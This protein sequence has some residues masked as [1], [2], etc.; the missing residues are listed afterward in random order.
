MSMSDTNYRTVE[1][2]TLVDCNWVKQRL[3][4]DNIC[5]LKVLLQ[6]GSLRNQTEDSDSI[7]I[8]NSKVFNISEFSENKDLPNMMI[9]E[10]DFKRLL[11]RYKISKDA[12]IVFYESSGVYASPRAWWMFY[13]MGF[14]KISIMS[15]SIYG[16]IKKGYPVEKKSSASTL[17]ASLNQRY[18][19]DDS[20]FC[21]LSDIYNYIDDKGYYQIVDARSAARF[22]GKGVFKKGQKSGHIPGSVNLPY[23]HFIKDGKY[24]SIKEIEELFLNLGV[25]KEKHIIFTCGSGITAC[26][27]ALAA[28]MVKFQKISVYDGSW[29]EWSDNRLNNPVEIGIAAGFNNIKKF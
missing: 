8:P 4:E 18:N 17:N 7:F 20:L 28:Y 29:T 21:K 26:I 9:C 27:L 22:M 25:K 23:S 6:K 13:A 16:W 14:K 24:I 10:S 1:D 11:T 5:I 15:D 2:P 3:N 12:H 19:K